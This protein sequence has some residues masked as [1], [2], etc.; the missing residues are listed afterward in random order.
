MCLSSGFQSSAFAQVCRMNK[1]LYRLR[2]LFGVGFQNS[3]LLFLSVGLYND[4]LLISSNN[5]IPIAKFKSYLH[6]CFHTKGLGPLKY[7]LG[8]EIANS[9]EDIYL[10]Q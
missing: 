10:S 7:L 6:S 9:K 1:S 8:I 5:A 4:D 2:Q 3:P